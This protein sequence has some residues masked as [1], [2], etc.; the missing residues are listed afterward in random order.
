MPHYLSGRKLILFVQSLL[1]PLQTLNDQFV[2]FAK[3]KRIEANM[4]SQVFYFEWF[5]NRKFRDYLSDPDDR[6]FIQD[7]TSI[8]VDLYYEGSQVS[9]P[10]TLWFE[11]E[12]AA[13]VDPLE[14]PR[15]LYLI[16]EEKQINKVSFM[17]CVP[18]I[19][20]PETEFVNMLSYWVNKYKI[21]GMTY[22]IKIDSKE[23]TPNNRV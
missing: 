4:T 22:L 13:T 16:A 6:I 17:V 20:I 18:E 11:G 21:A 1:Y 19:D 3:E 15:A 5:L 12:L 9:K 8:G 23:I 10:Y 7:S 14:E 2:R